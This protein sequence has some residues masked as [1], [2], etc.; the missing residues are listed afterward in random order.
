MFPTCSASQTCPSVA[1]A[2]SN[3]YAVSG[4]N[5]ESRTASALWL[6]SACSQILELDLHLAIP[7][8]PLLLHDLHNGVGLVDMC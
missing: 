1:C 5:G 7:E 6:A 3:T 4:P 2:Y 8:Q